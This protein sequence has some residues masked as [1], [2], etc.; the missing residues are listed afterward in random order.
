MRV[1]VCVALYCS[2]HFAC[3]VA[4]RNKYVLTTAKKDATAQQQQHERVIFSVQCVKKVASGSLRNGVGEINFHTNK[5]DWLHAL[6]LF[7]P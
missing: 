5:S 6:I 1:C 4:D 2:T 7:N 3:L